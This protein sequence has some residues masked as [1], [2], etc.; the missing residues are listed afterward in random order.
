[1]AKVRDVLDFIE[2]IAPARWAMPG[3][4]IGLQIGDPDAV[5]RRAVVT[6]DATASALAGEG[7]DA[8]DLVVSHHPII[9]NPLATLTPTVPGYRAIRTMVQNDIALIAAHTN[10]DAAPGGV[11]DALALRLGL[12]D[13]RAFGPATPVQSHKLI[14]FVPEPQADA[15]IDALAEA[16]AGVIGDYRRC[17][18]S[19]PGVGTFVGGEATNPAVGSPGRVETVSE[20]RVEMVVPA[21]CEK[22]VV[23]AL[24]ANHPYEEPAYDLVPISPAPEM[25]IGR[26]GV[27]PEEMSAAQLLDTVERRLHTKSWL[28]GSR[29]ANGRNVAV[30]GGAGGDLWS[31]AQSA[32]ADFFVTGEVKH[33]DGIAAEDGGIAVLA[34]GHYE[35]EQPGVEALAVALAEN[36]TDVEW[37]CHHVERTDAVG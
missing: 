13:I 24:V 26:I 37:R 35:T 23:A 5:V 10:W 4:R 30:V 1:M 31:A 11:N 20:L 27:L 28:M 17:A 29:K 16:G 21:G 19:S 12:A 6:L 3:D 36:L 8:V 22:A 7:S 32:G 9:W 2:Q 15:L 14:V 18:F 33:S 34:A 25:P